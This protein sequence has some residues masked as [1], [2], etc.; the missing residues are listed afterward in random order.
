[1]EGQVEPRPV[2]LDGQLDV[3]GS[4]LDRDHSVRKSDF[5]EVQHNLQNTYFLAFYAIGVVA[6]SVH[7]GNGV[8]NSSC[9]WGLAATAHSQGSAAW[10]GA[11][12]ALVFSLVGVAIV[13]SIRLNWRS[14]SN[15]KAEKDCEDLAKG[16]G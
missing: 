5:V 4:A 11:V 10:L 7:V 16:S 15:E 6:S 1:M 13:L 9:K 8:W 2:P 14:M 3:F 12:V